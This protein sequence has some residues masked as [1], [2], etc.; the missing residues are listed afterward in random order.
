MRK[1]V[2]ITG[3]AAPN[4]S[5]RP[6]ENVCVAGIEFD[7][8]DRASWIRFCPINFRHLQH[9]DRFKK[10][11]VVN[12]DCVPAMQDGRDVRGPDPSRPGSS[13]G[14][15]SWSRWRRSRTYDAGL[16]YPTRL[17]QACASASPTLGSSTPQGSA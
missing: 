16:A 7:E 9:D 14:S 6:G 5:E 15:Q 11:D 13:H 17:E 3:K 8:L 2:I 1:K 10:W 4:P 12:V